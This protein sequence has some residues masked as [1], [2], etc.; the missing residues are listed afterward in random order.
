MEIT[1]ILAKAVV[2]SLFAFAFYTWN[3]IR[4]ITDFNK[5]SMFYLILLL[6][7]LFLV[8]Y[9]DFIENLSIEIKSKYFQYANYSIVLFLVVFS[10]LKKKKDSMEIAF[11][12]PG[13]GL[14]MLWFVFILYQTFFTNI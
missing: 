12:K 14:L 9:V 1:S 11:L 5:R 3:R 4:I 10:R 13:I 8:V 6:A 2:Y 7:G